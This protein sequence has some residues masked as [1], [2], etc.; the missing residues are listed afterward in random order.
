[1]IKNWYFYFNLL[2]SIILSSLVFEFF[3]TC[4]S[5][6][7]SDVMDTYQHAEIFIRTNNVSSNLGVLFELCASYE[8]TVGGKNYKQ[9]YITAELR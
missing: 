8:R 2:E 3:K 6:Q 9:A 7:I 4:V 1:M 5:F